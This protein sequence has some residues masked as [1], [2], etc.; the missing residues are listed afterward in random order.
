MSSRKKPR[1]GYSG[2][3]DET[4]NCLVCI[5]A[6]I[7][8]EITST[9]LAPL[10]VLLKAKREVEVIYNSKNEDGRVGLLMTK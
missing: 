7:S 2:C 10:Y 1:S 5:S 9:G 4:R 8:E 3:A 6:E